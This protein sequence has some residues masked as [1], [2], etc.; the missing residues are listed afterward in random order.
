[1]NRARV[2]LFLPQKNEGF[3][4]PALEGMGLR[5]L[6]VC[7]DCVGNRDFC[8][9]G[10]SAFRPEFSFGAIARATGE[11]LRIDLDRAGALTDAARA[12]FDE[13]HIDR[14]RDAFQRILANLGQIW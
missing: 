2:T 4:L 11:A 6:I 10:R 13:H 1:M 3:Y 12:T 8:I 14:E 7:P 5:T 9:P